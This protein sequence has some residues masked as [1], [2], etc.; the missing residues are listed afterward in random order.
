MHYNYCHWATAHLQL[1]ILLLL[2]LFLFHIL[3][4]QIP[5]LV[6][7]DW[8]SGQVISVVLLSYSRQV[9]C[10]RLEA[11]HVRIRPRPFKPNMQAA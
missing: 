8:L 9:L 3:E 6:S 2:L 10:Q 5:N 11:D 7:G 4:V 1:N